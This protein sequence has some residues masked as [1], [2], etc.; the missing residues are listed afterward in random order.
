MT[1]SRYFQPIYSRASSIAV[2][3]KGGAAARL[4]VIGAGKMAEAIVGAI[5]QRGVQ[6]AGRTHVFDSNPSRMRHFATTWPGMYKHHSVGAAVEGADVVLLAVKPQ[7]MPVVLEQMGGVSP[8][9]L[10]I[11]IAAGCPISM[12]SEKL[13]TKSI[14]RCMPNTPAMIGE[15]MTVWTSLGCSTEQL[16]AAR[17]LISS[18]GDEAYVQEEH[19]LDMATAIV[20]SGPAYVY[21]FIEAMIDTGVHMGF[22]RETAVRLV[23]KTVEGSTAYLRQSNKHISALRNDITSPGGTT[24]AAI[25]T[26]DEGQFR[27][28]IANAIWAAYRRSLELGGKDSNVGPGRSQR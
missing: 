19:Y 18:F 12:F 20:G 28:T 17:Q 16:D 26:A 8:D 6:H 27:T 13:P 23:L 22:P 9:A 10:V 3:M 11:S 5:V 14:V 24:A 1:T 21:M 4:A 7:H 25:Y 15:G 2:E